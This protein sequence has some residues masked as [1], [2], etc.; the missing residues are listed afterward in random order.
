[1]TFETS[2]RTANEIAVFVTDIHKQAC[3]VMFI[4]ERFC[5]GILVCTYTKMSFH[6]PKKVSPQDTNCAG[7]CLLKHV[8]NG[9]DL[10][11]FHTDK[12]QFHN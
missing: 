5:D 11:A 9:L 2:T 8:Q 3:D 6:F 10:L 4:H 1:M 7:L 12:N